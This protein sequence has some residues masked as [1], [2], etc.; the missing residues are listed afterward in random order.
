[1][2]P[3]DLVLVGLL[4]CEF[5]EEEKRVRRV[6]A[7][8]LRAPRRGR[9]RSPAGV[10]NPGLLQRAGHPNRRPWLCCLL[11]AAVMSLR[12]LGLRV[13]ALTMQSLP[14]RPRRDLRSSPRDRGRAACATRTRCQYQP[15]V[16]TD[17]RE[18]RHEREGSAT[19][20]ILYWA[21][22]GPDTRHEMPKVEFEAA[23]PSL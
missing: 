3:A 22:S 1:M 12:G 23:A 9:A 11:P 13:A 15:S 16:R 14:Y 19:M 10:P 21:F 2:S 5:E 18:Q 17:Q 6:G 20:T 4:K 7:W 8:G